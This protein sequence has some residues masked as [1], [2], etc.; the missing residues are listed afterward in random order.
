MSKRTSINFAI[1]TALLLVAGGAFGYMYKVIGVKE[2]TLKTQLATIKTGNDRE[3]TYYRLQNIA[4]ESKVDRERLERYFLPQVGESITFL[5]QVETLAPQNGITL[6]TDALE[7][8]SDK[9]TKEKWVDAKFTF[10]GTRSNVEQFISTL[11][12]LPYVSKITS[13]QLS[14][15]SQNNWEARVSIRVFIT[16]YEK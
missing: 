15:R 8:G 3:Q 7:E 5:T 14:A 16:R 2:E 11:E 9:K 1:A 6:K 10:S 4:E 13:A 12:N